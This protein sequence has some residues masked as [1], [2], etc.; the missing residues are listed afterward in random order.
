VFAALV[1]LNL[2]ELAGVFLVG[3]GFWIG[4]SVSFVVMLADLV[5]LR[6]SALA[7]QRRRRAL[8]RQTAWVRAEQA[9]VRREHARR[10][11][12]RQADRRRL[13]AERSHAP[14][15]YVQHYSRPASS[16]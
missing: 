7:A 1:T 15:G 16:E 12:T 5:Y 13:A 8:A 3:P 11:A 2:V 9:A 14:S 10:A 6:R 4:F